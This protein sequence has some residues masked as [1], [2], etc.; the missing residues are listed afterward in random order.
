MIYLTYFLFALIPF[1]LL[2][3]LLL[4]VG[5]T[6]LESL[7]ILKSDNVNIDPIATFF[8]RCIQVGIYGGIGSAVIGILFEEFI[9]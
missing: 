6:I 5:G 8:V 9:M 4:L 7:G 3:M 2:G 1:G